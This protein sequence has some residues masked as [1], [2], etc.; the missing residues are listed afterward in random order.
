MKSY[1]ILQ[2]D[3]N[4]SLKNVLDF[5][6]RERGNDVNDW[7]NLSN[8]F[9]PIKGVIDNSDAAAG[10][11]GEYVESIVGSGSA[12]S[13]VS[14]TAKT[15]TSISLS[16]GDWDV[17]GIVGFTGGS[18]TTYGQVTASISNTANT[19]AAAPSGGFVQQTWG[20][21]LPVVGAIGTP[22]IA[23]GLSRVK[24]SAQTTIYLIAS[25]FFTTSTF[26]A[27]GTIRARRIR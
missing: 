20:G 6:T 12:V 24:I 19:H 26:S 7:N 1:P 27:F 18:T 2:D 25:A 14:V 22:S 9:Y 23:T 16:A 4:A 15:V 10:N 11:V 5:I 8:R 17:S 21:T 13:L 3:K